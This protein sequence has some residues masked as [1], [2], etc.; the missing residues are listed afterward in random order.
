[1]IKIN[2]FTRTNFQSIP[3]VKYVGA[4]FLI[5]TLSIVHS[6]LPHTVDRQ[7][8]NAQQFS[9]NVELCVVDLDSIRIEQFKE[10][11]EGGIVGSFFGLFFPINKHSITHNRSFHSSQ[12]IYIP[13]HQH[14][15]PS[16]PH[17]TDTTT[18]IY[19]DA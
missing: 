15:I 4:F 17:N 2:L 9:L 7:S 19:I 13:S 10:M 16:N 1:M 14:H 3:N 11:M 12:T 8:T 5:W 18:Y 6:F